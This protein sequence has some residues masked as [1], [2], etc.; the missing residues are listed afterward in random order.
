MKK[1]KKLAS[2]LLVLVMSLA[3]TVP[4]F[5]ATR[6]S[7]YSYDSNN[8]W[9]SGAG[10]NYRMFSTFYLGINSSSR[11]AAVWVREDSNQIIPSGYVTAR[12]ILCDSAGDSFIE[13][14]SKSSDGRDIFVTASTRTTGDTKACSAVGYVT[15]RGGSGQYT[16]PAYPRNLRLNNELSKS[17]TADGKYPVNSRGETY[18][19]VML[20]YQVGQGPDLIS[21]VNSDGVRGYVRADD[22]LSD[23]ADGR[24]LSL[25]DLDGNVIG[26][27]G[28]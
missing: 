18:G 24:L 5:A 4:A 28:G 19:S 1:M 7:Y 10:Y 16:Q 14:G 27:F 23:N 6:E 11:Y 20:A 3:L 13:G 26:T 22:F 25:Y 15:I 12:A 21:A 8:S 17:L 2:L 9:A